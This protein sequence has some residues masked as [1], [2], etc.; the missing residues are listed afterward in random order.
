MS[1]PLE[2]PEIY[3]VPHDGIKKIMYHSPGGGRKGVN[4]SNLRKNGKQY[5]NNWEQ[6]NN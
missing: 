3:V 4:L 5:L 2:L 1:N 6:L